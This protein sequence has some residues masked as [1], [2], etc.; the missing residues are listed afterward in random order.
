MDGARSE[1]SDVGCS[2]AA[3]CPLFPFLRGSLQGWRE[4][5][6]DSE[7]RWL[8]CARYQTSLTGERVP[9]SL[10]PNGARA[11]HLE[12]EAEA[13][14]SGAASRSAPGRPQERPARETAAPQA[15]DRF[16]AAPS[17][18]PRDRSAPPP[19]VPAP[20]DGRAG[21]TRRA[22]G[23]KSGWW[24]RFADWMRGPA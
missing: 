1:G 10:L 16:G 11:R 23:P 8:G 20:S 6:C 14:R 5:Y 7:D 12:A 18:V 3:G 15:T 19:Q 24:T 2:H 21:H 9:I 17:P 22:A 13:G 4:Y